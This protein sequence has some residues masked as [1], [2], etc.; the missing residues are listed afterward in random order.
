MPN[1][2][3]V[4]LEFVRAGLWENG[5]VNDSRL[6]VHDYS[7]VEWEEVYRLA[8]EQ[9]VL[10]VVLAGIETNSLRP[11]QK[12]LLQWIGEVQM[13]EQQNKAM[14]QFIAKL[15]GKM[16]EADIYTLLVKGQG[17]AQCYE[18]PLWRTSG[19]VDLLLDEE[20]YEK[21]KALLIP[22]ADE[23]HG[24]DVGRKHQGLVIKGFNVELHGRMPFGLSKKV[25]GVLDEVIDKANT[26][27]TDGKDDLQG[28]A[29][30]RPDE[31]VLIVFTHFLHHFFL[32]GVGLRQICDW[33]RLLW[34]YR[35]ELDLRLLEQRI[36][37]AGL[38]SEW[39]AFAA[40]AVDYLGMPVEAMPMYDAR[41]T[42]KG[43]KI[44]KRVLKCG[45]F[46]HNNDLS[47]RSKYTGMKYKVVATWRR[48]MGF[49]SLVPVFPL[50]APRFFVGYLLGKK[51]QFTGET[52]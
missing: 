15:V 3:Q 41:F 27:Y 50:D 7:S 48:F 13:L 39:R 12:L 5:L 43:K 32:E 52:I 38:M 42:V 47:Y 2:Q 4:F 34:R 36:R 33:C 40:L 1:N 23:V 17:V 45:N 6:M 14:N 8:S 46:G 29:I 11:P 44:L 28:V 21:A 35:S 18:R 19:D 51:M 24:E 26:D 16:R 9:S 25:D 22:I 30:P 37:K 20:N 49:A 31:H 10:G